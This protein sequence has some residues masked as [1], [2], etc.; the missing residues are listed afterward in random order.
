MDTSRLT[1]SA[2]ERFAQAVDAVMDADDLS[3]QERVA[4]IGH[5]AYQYQR[6]DMPDLLAQAIHRCQADPETLMV[7]ASSKINAVTGQVVP[8]SLHRY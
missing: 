5:W 2:L 1:H 8:Y 7:T 3:C 4:L 6:A